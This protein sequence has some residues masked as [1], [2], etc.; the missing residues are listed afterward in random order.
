MYDFKLCFIVSFFLPHHMIASLHL[1]NIILQFSSQTWK[2]ILSKKLL[3]MVS[4]YWIFCT[5]LYKAIYPVTVSMFDRITRCRISSV[6]YGSWTCDDDIRQLIT[7]SWYTA[8][9]HVIVILLIKW[10]YE[11]HFEELLFVSPKKARYRDY[12]RRWYRRRRWHPDFLVRSI[13]LS[14]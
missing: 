14:L 1:K 7:W 2:M 6:I 11:N 5:F 10:Y 8:V 3:L 9:D 13:T 4:F 12:F